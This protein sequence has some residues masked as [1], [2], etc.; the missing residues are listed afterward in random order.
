MDA[1]HSMESMDFV[2]S[3]EFRGF[4]EAMVVHFAFGSFELSDSVRGGRAII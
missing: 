1:I 3:V 4:M 2:E